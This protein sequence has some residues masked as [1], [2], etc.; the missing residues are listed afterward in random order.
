MKI[1]GI[2][3]S[4]TGTTSL[5]RAL[6]ILGYRTRDYMGVTR[7]SPGD[8]SCVDE[9]ELEAH[10]AFTDTPIPSFYREL[11]VAYPGS[12]FILTVRDKEGWLNSCKK[13]FNQKLAAK[14]NEASIKVFE[15]L[16]GT[17]VF[18]EAH[19]SKG[20]DRFVSGVE[21]Y[22]KERH[23]DLLILDVTAGEGWE[24]L[25]PF[26]DKPIPDL[27]FPKANVTSIR[28][29]NIDDVAAMVREASNE[30]FALY[31]FL[32]PMEM[33]KQAF[34][35]PHF[36]TRIRHFPTW[37]KSRKGDA[38]SAEAAARAHAR[39]LLEDRLGRLNQEVP[40][41]LPEAS[42]KV[43]EAARRS[44][45]HFW[46]I[47]PFTRI[48][49]ANSTT[50]DFITSVALIEDRFPILGIVHLPR[51]DTTYYAMAGKGAFKR[52]RDGTLTNLKESN[53]KRPVPGGPGSP[54]N[55]IENVLDLC[56]LASGKTMVE[57]IW[58]RSREWQTAPGQIIL[59]EAGLRL[60]ECDHGESLS[61]NKANF[62]NPCVRVK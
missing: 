11:D 7:Y 42:N 3:L 39:H 62:D 58:E 2:G 51:D 61:Y 20:Y 36:V 8:L 38:S 17:A 57:P 1:F 40:M 44:W 23:E 37:W 56:R 25:C 34:G 47:D 54:K 4:K 14:Q 9:R 33:K 15:D 30:S 46:L 10:D 18:E 53:G 59:K 22:F 35:H 43:S 27:P 29:M 5:A 19:F 50:P 52:S 32:H 6:E 28:W 13:Q 21:E 45:N 48:D 24:K 12:K 26:L 60:V 49:T 31:S 55:R 16:Y 41:V